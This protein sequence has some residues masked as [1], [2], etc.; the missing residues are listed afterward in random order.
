MLRR[1]R[2][3]RRQWTPIHIGA[4]IGLLVALGAS[5]RLIT[6]PTPHTPGTDWRLAEAYPHAQVADVHGY[7]EAGWSYQ[8]ELFLDLHTSVGPSLAAK[9]GQTR[10]IVARDGDYVTW[11]VLD[12]RSLA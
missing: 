6:L 5:A 10:M 1:V 9:T 4:A 3:G 7:V 11:H 8:P 2:P 12:L